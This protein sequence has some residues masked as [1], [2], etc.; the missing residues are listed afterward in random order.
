MDFLHSLDILDSVLDSPRS[1]RCPD[2]VRPVLVRTFP[3]DIYSVPSSGLWIVHKMVQQVQNGFVEV[4]VAQ[5]YA[6]R[7]SVRYCYSHYLPKR[8]LI[9]RYVYDSLMN[10]HL[11]SVPGRVSMTCAIAAGGLHGHDP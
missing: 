9:C 8:S 7:N 5:G 11:P 1:D 3:N 4:L 6:Y 10:S 2:K